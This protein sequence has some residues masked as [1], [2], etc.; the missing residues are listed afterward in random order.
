[1]AKKKSRAVVKT[2]VAPKVLK[3]FDCPFCSHLD[4]VEVKME[5]PKGRGTLN[6][7]VCSVSY[8]KQPLGKLTKEVDIYCEWIDLADE[9]NNPE[10]E[11]D[12]NNGGLG[13]VLPEKKKKLT[14]AITP[15][16]EDEENSELVASMLDEES[17]YEGR[18]DYKKDAHKK[19][20]HFDKE[21]KKI[22]DAPEFKKSYGL[23]QTVISE[24]VPQKSEKSLKE[25]QKKLSDSE[26]SSDE[27]EIDDLF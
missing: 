17:D 27:S 24:K 21:E 8:Q 19:S 26:G 14:T 11:S 12:E 15:T 6:C 20:T 13:M 22:E 10:Y 5:R 3:T 4:T 7:R 16:S 9:M 18:K 25:A 23:G 2:A 1:M